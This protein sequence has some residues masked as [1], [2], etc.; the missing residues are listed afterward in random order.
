MSF[1]DKIYVINLKKRPNKKESIS[2]RL[3]L[4]GLGAPI[5]FV[6]AF[7][8]RFVDRNLLDYW[9]KEQ[10]FA[11]YKNWKTEASTPYEGYTFDD[12]DKRGIT[13]AE[14]GCFLR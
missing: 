9:L 12:W 8:L 2:K 3:L 13:N 7:D 14:I 11:T 6:E 5:E 1:V 10:G 4:E